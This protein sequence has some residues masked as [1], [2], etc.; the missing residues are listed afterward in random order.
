M[1]APKLQ[2]DDTGTGAETKAVAEYL[3]RFAYALPGDKF[4]PGWICQ[5][6]STVSPGQFVF[7]D[8]AFAAS[9]NELEKLDVGEML[10]DEKYHWEGAGYAI[11]KADRRY[12]GFVRTLIERSAPTQEQNVTETKEKFIAHISNALAISHNNIL[13]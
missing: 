13:D 8:N 9:K 12:D 11:R 3:R 7:K 5:V 4:Q 2:G 10:E 1:E 6:R